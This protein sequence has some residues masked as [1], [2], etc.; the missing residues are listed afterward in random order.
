[1]T[2][3][4][5]ENLAAAWDNHF[6]AFGAQDVDKILLDYDD[7]SKIT[8]WNLVTDEKEVYE[9]VEGARTLFE[10]LFKALPDLSDLGAPLIELEECVPGMPLVDPQETTKTVFLIWRC[11]ASG[12]LDAVDNFIFND[13]LKIHRQT[14][15]FRPS[16]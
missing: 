4:A 3:Y 16:A 14:V 12:I 1:M 2:A 8:T 13:D 9:G 5:P 11:P 10:G 7:N 6:S 15:A